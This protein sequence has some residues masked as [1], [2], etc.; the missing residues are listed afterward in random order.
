MHRDLK[1]ENLLVAPD[2]RAK[3]LDFGLAGILTAGADGGRDLARGSTATLLTGPHAVLGAL[4]FMAPERARGEP[5]DSRS[6][7]SALGA[8]LYGAPAFALEALAAGGATRRTLRG[9]AAVAAIV[10]A[11][12]LADA[13]AALGYGNYLVPEDSFLRARAAAA[14]AVEL[15]PA[16]AAAHSRLGYAAMYYDWDFGN[17]G[18]E[19]ERAL[20]LDPLSP[21]IQTDM[22]FVAHYARRDD[23]ATDRQ[24][25]NRAGKSSLTEIMH[26]LLGSSVDNDS[27]FPDTQLQ[28]NSTPLHHLAME[29]E[30]EELRWYQI[31]IGLRQIDTLRQ[32]A[33]VVAAPS[34]EPYTDGMEVPLAPDTARRPEDLAATSGPAAGDIVEDALAGCLEDLASVRQTLDGRHDDLE[35]GRVKPCAREEARVRSSGRSTHRF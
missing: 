22:A 24:T 28:G 16:L 27:V 7:L 23:G 2:G 10:A 5:A 35:S 1:P 29:G 6:D 20:A 25:R 3:I 4:R 34:R 33:R 14:Q 21:A 32:A 11:V 12:G 18:A 19:L 26:F 30:G 13:Y 31:A 17:A 15:D 9:L 8:V